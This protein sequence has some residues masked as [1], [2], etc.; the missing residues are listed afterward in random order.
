ML[1]TRTCTVHRS[2]FYLSHTSLPLYLN[3]AHDV[4]LQ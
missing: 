4:K 3:K 2:V 1:D